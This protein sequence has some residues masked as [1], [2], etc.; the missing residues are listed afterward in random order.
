MKKFIEDF[1]HK[2]TSWFAKQS[3]IPQWLRESNRESHFIISIYASLILTIIFSLG[4]GLG[5]EYKDKMHNDNWDNLDLLATI[6]GGVVGQIIQI[7]II[8]I[9]I[10]FL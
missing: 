3:W 2:Q 5:M 9:A 6:L 8:L 1:I 4:L 7:I 10:L